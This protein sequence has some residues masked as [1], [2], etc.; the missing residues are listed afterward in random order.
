MDDSEDHN[1][2]TAAGDEDPTSELTL[3]APNAEEIKRAD[4]EN[5]EEGNETKTTR[6]RE[7]INVLLES[8]L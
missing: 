5:Q 6:R 3:S 2:N 8:L 4:G 1:D 7:V